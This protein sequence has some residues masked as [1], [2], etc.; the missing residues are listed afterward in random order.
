MA[1]AKLLPPM[2]PGEILREEFMVP[3]RISGRQLAKA[4]G[5]HQMRISRILQGKLRITLDTA[6]RLARFFGVTP[7]FWMNLQNHYDLELLKGPEMRAMIDAIPTVQE[8]K[9]R[10]KK[11]SA[12]PIRKGRKARELA[13][14]LH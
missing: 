8:F 5:I 7:E 11:V 4:I 14:T 9:A 3:L 1:K 12:K 13:G 6:A 2:P 10:L